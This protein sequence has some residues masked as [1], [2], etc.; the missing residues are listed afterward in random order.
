[1]P[2]FIGRKDAV[3]VC[4]T[5]QLPPANVSGDDAL[6]HFQAR[7]FTAQDLAALIGAHTASRQF[8]TD[9]AHVGSSQD[10]TP[11]IW[12]IKY[13]V[14]T[15][16]GTAPF[17]F[18]SDINI[19]KQTSTAPFFKQFST[20]KAAWDTAFTAAMQKMSLLGSAGSGSMVDCTG[21]LPQSHSRRD[22]KAAPIN[23]RAR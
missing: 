20:D 18:Q 10:S 8:V 3:A 4:P 21:A 13:F 7:G 16:L 9:P 22:A 14:E 23:A 5:G 12:D 1:V 15:L 2:V 11:S 19:S 17:S 6:S